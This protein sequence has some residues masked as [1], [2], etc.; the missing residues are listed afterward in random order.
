M[1]EKTLPEEELE[2]IK[3]KI[4][5]YMDNSEEWMMQSF[6]PERMAHAVDVP[7]RLLPEIIRSGFGTNFYGLLNR[8][9]IKE[10]CR[11]LSDKEKLKQL[12][13]EGISQSLGF[14]S[15]SNFGRNFR[16]LVGMSPTEYIAASERANT[17]EPPRPD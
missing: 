13:I 6:S 1:K 10:A 4:S 8:Y 14:K 15:R 11:L 17:K 5:D 12:T 16:N 2:E 9:R 3:Q 7:V